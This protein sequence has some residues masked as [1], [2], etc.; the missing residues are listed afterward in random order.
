MKKR[1]LTSGC[2]IANG[3]GTVAR[4][5]V[6]A[7]ALLTIYPAAA[8]VSSWTGT[9]NVNLSDASNWQNLSA[10]TANSI[11]SFAALSSPLPYA[12]INDLTVPISKLSFAEGSYVI[13][14][15]A[16]TLSPLHSGIGQNDVIDT[17][18]LSVTGGTQTINSDIVLQP[19]V[20]D[21]V[22]SQQVVNN[23]NVDVAAG[24]LTLN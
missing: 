12:L 18:V 1:T 20:I 8:S 19:L 6:V 22:L 5:S 15:S 4:L 24:S 17:T 16:L 2:Q 23:F 9:A 7:L 10:P 21:R 13:S 3:A 11:L 14:G